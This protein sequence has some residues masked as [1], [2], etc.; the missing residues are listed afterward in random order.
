MRYNAIEEDTPNSIMEGFLEEVRTLAEKP[1]A[2]QAYL[3]SE[4]I[5][6]EQK[7]RLFKNTEVPK[8]MV[9]SCKGKSSRHVRKESGEDWRGLGVLQ[10]GHWSREEA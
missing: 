8:G 6:Q 3:N 9:L 7:G 1:R 4:W 2:W 5:I 10:E